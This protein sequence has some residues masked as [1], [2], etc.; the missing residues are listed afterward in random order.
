[1][2]TKED[3]IKAASEY[4]LASFEEGLCEDNGYSSEELDDAI[5]EAREAFQKFK[6]TLDEFEQTLLNKEEKPCNQ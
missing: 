1:M 3:V 2:A 4:G 6:Q 5:K